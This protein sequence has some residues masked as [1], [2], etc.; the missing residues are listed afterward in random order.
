MTER[1]DAG[2]IVRRVVMREQRHAPKSDF[3]DGKRKP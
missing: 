2:L 3:Y 1:A